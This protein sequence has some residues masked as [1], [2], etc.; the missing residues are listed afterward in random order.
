MRV[1]KQKRNSLGDSIAF[2]IGMALCKAFVGKG[3]K[4]GKEHLDKKRGKEV[5]VAP[6][7]VLL[8]ESTWQSNLMAYN[9]Q[10]L[11]YSYIIILV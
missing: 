8:Y 4:E 6:V 2:S 9:F 1:G 7:M 10:L 11:E 5:R 3:I